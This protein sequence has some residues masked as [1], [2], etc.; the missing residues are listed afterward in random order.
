VRTSEVEWTGVIY[1]GRGW[2]VWMRG[3]RLSDGCGQNTGYNKE[4]PSTFAFSPQEQPSTPPEP[5]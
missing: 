2:K 3:R 1:T 5:P 4:H